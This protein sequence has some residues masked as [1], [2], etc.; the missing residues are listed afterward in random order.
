MLCA[1]DC[2][3]ALKTVRVEVQHGTAVRTDPLACCLA[4]ATGRFNKHTALPVLS[5]KLPKN[6]LF[7]AYFYKLY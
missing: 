7:I 3:V 5:K 1:K 2:R 6:H 4:A